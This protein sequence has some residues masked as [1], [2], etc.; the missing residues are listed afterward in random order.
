MAHSFHP[1]SLVLSILWKLLSHHQGLAVR[2][3]CETLRG[4]GKTYQ[5]KFGP[6]FH[7][8]VFGLNS[9]RRGWAASHEWSEHGGGLLVAALSSLLPETPSLAPVAMLTLL[10][11]GWEQGA[12]G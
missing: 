12:S 6:P 2:V 9:R 8:Q 4:T 11:V 5:S 3:S 7:K 1:P 10:A